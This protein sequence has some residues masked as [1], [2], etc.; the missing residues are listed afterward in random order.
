[1]D[2]FAGLPHPSPSQSLG[3]TPS[4]AGHEPSASRAPGYRLASVQ[5]LPNEML[6]TIFDYL[7]LSAHNQCA[8]VCRRWH[9]CLPLTRIKRA[10]WLERN[11]G[12]SPLSFNRLA[13][14][15]SSRTAPWLARQHRPVLPELQRQYQQWQDLLQ[16]LEPG[17]VM[18]RGDFLA[19]H[20]KQI[21]TAERFL[22]GLVRFHMKQQI[23]QANRLTL[24]PVPFSWP[25]RQ[26]VT[27]YLFSPCSRWL[28]VT[29]VF[30][31][32]QHRAF[33]HFLH[34]YGYENARWTPQTLVPA[35]C[36]PV[37]VTTFTYTPSDALLSAHGSEVLVWRKQPDTGDWHR[38]TL[39][40]TLPSYSIYMLAPMSNGDIITLSE[41]KDTD[42]REQ[43][44]FVLLISRYQDDS[45][46]EYIPYFDTFLPRTN[47]IEPRSCRLALGGGCSPRCH[48][49]RHV[50]TVDLWYKS[51]GANSLGG[52]CY[53]ESVLAESSA[54]L[55][56]IVFSPQGDLLLIR[57]LNR[58]FS[59]WA[60]DTECNLLRMPLNVPR[61]LPESMPWT[62]LAKFRSD[63]RQLAVACTPYR[64]QFVNRHE[65]GSWQVGNTLE[66]PPQAGDRLESDN[67][68][69]AMM[70]SSNGRLLVWLTSWRVDIWQQGPADLWHRV[71]Q[72][73]RQAAMHAM[74]QAGLLGEL[75]WTLATDPLPS[76]WLHSLNAQGQLIQKG[77]IIVTDLVT[78]VNAHSPDGLSLVLSRPTATPLVLQLEA[79]VN[80]GPQPGDIQP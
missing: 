19:G 46:A 66:S 21:L 29:G 6:C 59:L 60:L 49:N 76:L 34:L 48:N 33:P 11:P 54:H 67:A 57:L 12:L 24:S 1:M 23:L 41:N 5:A 75:V 13:Q 80:P 3:T 25:D 78:N 65:D 64:I 74:P 62:H 17:A 32:D 53:R 26:V 36:E 14:G 39:C 68:P 8:L 37:S 69:C 43:T 72:R 47:A 10:Q 51:T 61:S 70:L 9:A 20:K 58:C 73:T 79:S 40:C 30:S 28:V 4:L 56:G 7:P 27:G 16:R 22:S 63:G 45:W 50:N 77:R 52:W 55:Q 18:G 42:N 2:M 71:V 31:Q 44:G 15:Y 35:A 38:S